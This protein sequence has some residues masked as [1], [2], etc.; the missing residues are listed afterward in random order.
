MYFPPRSFAELHRIEKE[1]MQHV[2]AKAS[3]MIFE[4]GPPPPSPRAPPPAPK[5]LWDPEAPAVQ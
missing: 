5:L 3:A 2:V 4:E 1:L